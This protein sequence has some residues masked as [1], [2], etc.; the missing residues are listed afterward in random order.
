MIEKLLESI[1]LDSRCR[2]LVETAYAKA[3]SVARIEQTDTAR[4]VT[5]A[6]RVVHIAQSGE[7]NLWRIVDFALK[8]LHVG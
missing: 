5:I 8:D 1:A 7:T 3:L 6:C 2:T 4:K